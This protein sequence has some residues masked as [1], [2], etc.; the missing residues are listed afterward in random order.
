MKTNAELPGRFCAAGHGLGARDSCQNEE[1]GRLSAS[2][3]T[4]VWGGGWGALSL[5]PW[6]GAGCQGM[7]ISQ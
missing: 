1:P 2:N 3:T 4:G 7:L 5:E 6:E